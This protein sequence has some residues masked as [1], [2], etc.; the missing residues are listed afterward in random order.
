LTPRPDF[1]SCYD[2]IGLDPDEI[3]EPK[4][5]KLRVDYLYKLIY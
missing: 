2:L 5:T 4:T 3:K 1:S